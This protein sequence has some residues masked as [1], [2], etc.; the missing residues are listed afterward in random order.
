[1]AEFITQSRTSSQAQIAL[2]QFMNKVYGWMMLGL[3]LSALSSYYILS[4]GLINTIV[5]NKLVFFGLIFAQLGIVL[6][7]SFAVNRISSGAAH[8]LFIVYTLLTGV[9]LSV[10]MM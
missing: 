9:T 5:H 10:L 7:L 2:S 8:A 3:A 1:M 6:G 4:S